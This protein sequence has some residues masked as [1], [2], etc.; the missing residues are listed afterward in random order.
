MEKT[1]NDNDYVAFDEF[2]DNE[3]ELDIDAFSDRED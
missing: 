1:L 3:A 2:L